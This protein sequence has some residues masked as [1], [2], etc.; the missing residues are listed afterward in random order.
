MKDGQYNDYIKKQIENNEDAY[1]SQVVDDKQSTWDRIEERLETKKVIPLWVYSVAASVL[2]LIGLV[3][4]FNQRLNS[5]NVEIA[6]LE[7]LL[8]ASK[9]QVAGQTPAFAKNQVVKLVD[10]V[11]IVQERIVYVPQ[12]VLDT[13]VLH[14]TVNHVVTVKDT[15]FVNKKEPKLFVKNNVEETKKQAKNPNAVVSKVALKKKRKM[16][17]FIFLFGKPKN[18]QYSEEA[19]RLI[20]LRTK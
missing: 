17:R 11:K 10:T 18:E 5:K 2:I 4:V 19:Q 8:E 1:Y 13:I 12:Q 6:R 15:V 16:G 9:N 14:D 7:A 20:T 3:F